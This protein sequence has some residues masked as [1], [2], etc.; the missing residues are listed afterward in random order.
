MDDNE[1]TMEESVEEKGK[2]R[3][4]DIFDRNKSEGASRLKG[5]D[6]ILVSVDFSTASKRAVFLAQSLLNPRGVIYAIH[7]VPDVLTSTRDYVKDS[8]LK[9]LQNRITKE[10]LDKLT[11]WVEKSVKTSLKIEYVVGA[12]EPASEII[13]AARSKGA[14]IIV[15]GAHGQD[16]PDL[17]I[18]G[19]TVDKVIRKS[20]CPV[21]CVPP[22]KI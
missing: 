18:L 16:R 2:K 9:Q 15:M 22:E 10:G 7:V 4:L 20:D 17:G 14:Q 21:L 6:R 5:F 19:S 3:F 8:G 13:K 1:E 11:K 12:G